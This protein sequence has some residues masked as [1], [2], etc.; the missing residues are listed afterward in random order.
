MTEYG[1][2]KELINFYHKK[3]SVQPLLHHMEKLT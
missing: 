2:L 3:L 1:A